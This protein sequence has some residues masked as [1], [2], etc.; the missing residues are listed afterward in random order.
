MYTRLT[1]TTI[2]EWTARSGIQWRDVI[3]HQSRD[4]LIPPWETCMAF[5]RI[6]SKVERSVNRRLSACSVAIYRRLAALFLLPPHSIPSLPQCETLMSALTR[7]A[8]MAS[9]S[10]RS[11]TAASR[12]STITRHL[13][14]TTVMSAESSY[15]S[16]VAEV[17][18]VG[19]HH[20]ER[21]DRSYLSNTAPRASP[22]YTS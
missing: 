16:P 19:V 12:L 20:F 15:Q 9:S 6:L 21:A 17:S 4:L 8:R 13:S 10:S 7:S 3:V 2:A 11:L 1:R 18:P 5:C 14:S 22:G